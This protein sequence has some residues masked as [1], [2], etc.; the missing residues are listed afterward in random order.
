MS[1]WG[2]ALLYITKNKASMIEETPASTK[3][4]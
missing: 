1:F 3:E 2:G 4:K